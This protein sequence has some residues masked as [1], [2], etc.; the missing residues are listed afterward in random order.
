MRLESAT[1]AA[2][3][4]KRAAAPA[5][6]EAFGLH[7]S[8]A[9]VAVDESDRSRATRSRRTSHVGRAVVLGHDQSPSSAIGSRMIIS[10]ERVSSSFSCSTVRP[11]RAQARS[12]HGKSSKRGYPRSPARL[13]A[14]A[15]G[16]AHARK[17]RGSSVAQ[18]SPSW[19]PC[20]PCSS[21]RSAVRS[22]AGARRRPARTICSAA[23]QA[24]DRAN[25][26]APAAAATKRRK[27]P[28]L[29]RRG[30]DPSAL[31]HGAGPGAESHAGLVQVRPTAR[32]VG[33]T[34]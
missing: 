16:S 12:P 33:Q 27:R 24:R 8:A 11:S 26:R 29:E 4:V 23:G 3:V 17:R 9:A 21:S 28:A 20:E 30:V 25:C 19:S 15:R 22:E 7:R 18:C 31:A 2:A 1:H 13:I 14:R 10:L 32:Q 34:R 5:R 6:V